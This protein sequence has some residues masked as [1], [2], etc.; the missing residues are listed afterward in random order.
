MWVTVEVDRW[1]DFPLKESPEWNALD[2]GRAD[3]YIKSEGRRYRQD[4]PGPNWDGVGQMH[5]DLVRDEVGHEV[6]E[7]VVYVSTED[8]DVAYCL[9]CGPLSVPEV[10]KQ[11]K[12]LVGRMGPEPTAT[13]RRKV[14][15]VELFYELHGDGE[16][17]V[18]FIAG[19]GGNCCFWREFQV[20]D[21]S[22]KHRVLI[23]D[24]RGTGESSKPD[25]CYSTRMFADD[26]VCLMDELGL[27]KAHVIGH[28]MGGRVTQW[29]ALDHPERVKSVV[30]S[31]TGPGRWPGRVYHPSGIPFAT[32]REI[33]EKGFEK[34]M[35]DHMDSPFMHSPEFRETE[36]F[37][38]ISQ[39]SVG[40]LQPLYA[41]LRHVEARQAHQTYD[42]IHRI[43]VPTLV[44]DGA[45]DKDNDHF[46][47]LHYLAEKIPT[48][49][50]LKLLPGLRHGYLREAPDKAN[51]ILLD[52]IDQVSG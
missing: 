46:T 27:E 29:V 41:Y 36:Q 51:P 42:I 34:Y 6:P 30:L 38:R 13:P 40:G 1:S 11:W 20:P 33:A 48:A 50:E 7:H 5:Y 12:D 37:Q 23:Y 4:W 32:A 25:M 24:H 47:G 9:E 31:G 10:R 44:I 26:V 18:V 43:Q 14:K 52:W 35:R 28:S 39:L 15:D 8:R 2:S 22:R 21:F 49:G 45:D 19:T 3:L 17:V 16:E